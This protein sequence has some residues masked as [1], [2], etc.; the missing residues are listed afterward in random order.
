MSNDVL[1]YGEKAYA[2]L[3]EGFT[4]GEWGAFFDLLADEVDCI[5]P[6]PESGHFKGGEG[7]EK[8]VQ[9][10]GQFAK[11]AAEFE[12]GGLVGMT[13]AEDR[14]V[15]EDWARGK[16]FNEPYAARHCLHIMI[17]DSK[18]V[19]FHEYNRPLD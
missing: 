12:E 15:V 3:N 19:G 13:V 7:R 2:A 4:T 5:L 16:V 11:G 8:M 10:F 9:F 1:V 18:I 17:S 6:A 14:V